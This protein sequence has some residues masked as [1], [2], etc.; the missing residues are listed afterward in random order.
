MRI[1]SFKISNYDDEQLRKILWMLCYTPEYELKWLNEDEVSAEYLIKHI[2]DECKKSSRQ[3]LF[4]GDKAIADIKNIDLGITNGIVRDVII[5]RCYDAVFHENHCIE[6]AIKLLQT[7]ESELE[8]CTK[9]I[10]G[11]LLEI[12]F[13]SKEALYIRQT[14]NCYPI[15]LLLDR[16]NQELQEKQ[17]SGEL[18]GGLGIEIP[19]INST[20][21]NPGK[22]IAVSMQEKND[23]NSI[24]VSVGSLLKNKE[25]ISKLLSPESEAF[26]FNGLDEISSEILAVKERLDKLCDLENDLK[27]LEADGISLGYIAGRKDEIKNFYVS[28]EALM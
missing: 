1:K 25:I 18:R 16:Y 23:S 4:G 20:R 7:E 22:L 15:G 10:V 6:R 26:D 3:L 12:G 8:S 21:S 19:L 11:G 28:M 14:C 13:S 27:N 17:N 9:R 24:P 5:K 2:F